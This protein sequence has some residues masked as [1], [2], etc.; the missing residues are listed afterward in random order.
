MVNSAPFP[1]LEVVILAAGK[2]TRMYSSTPKVLHAIAGQPLLGHVIAGAREL[3]AKAIHV[4]IGYEGEKVQ[5]AFSGQALNWALQQEQLGTGHAVAQAL[6]QVD[7]DSMVLV[8]YGDVPLIRAETLRALTRRCTPDT[9]ALLTVMSSDPTGLGRILRSPEEKVV[10][11]VEEKDA[12]PEQ[13]Q[14]RETNSGI[15]VAPAKRLREWL[16]A[17]TP[18]NAQG[19]YYLTDIIAMAATAGC[20]VNSVVVEDELEVLGVNNKLQLAQLE[21][22]YQARRARELLLTGV[23]LRDPARVDIR[24]QVEC[25]RDVEIDVNVI[26]EGNV[27]LEDNVSIG[28]NVIIRNSHIGSGTQVLANSL[29]EDADVQSQCSI[30]PYARLRPGTQ[31]ADGAKVGNFVE[32]K[33]A[34]IGKGSKVNHLSYIGDATVGEHVNIGAGTITC[35]YDGVNK[36][37]TVIADGAFIGSNTALVAPVS[38]GKNAT[39]GAG[40]T[41]NQD[42]EAEDLSVARGRQRNIKGWKR[43]TKK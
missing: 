25:G 42:V 41:I 22:H 2:G 34:V 15:L 30:G 10:A 40:S 28:P 18:Q 26:F 38:I 9:L 6:P 37:Q 24:G 14:I 21:R 35:N 11:I 27:E 39:V 23:T 36:F 1:P 33:K 19:E 43:P 5:Q 31:L 20:A 13:R 17:L 4:V 16:G 29:I 8:L 12:T 3:G 32:I 7:D